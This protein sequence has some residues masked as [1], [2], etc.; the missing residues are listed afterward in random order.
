MFSVIFRALFR[1][2]FWNW[3][4]RKLLWHTLQWI[5]ISVQSSF[6]KKII[7][8]L[9]ITYIGYSCCRCC[10]CS[11]LVTTCW[12]LFFMPKLQLLLTSRSF[13]DF[14]CYRGQKMVDWT[15]GQS[16]PIKNVYLNGLGIRFLE[17]NP[18]K[19]SQ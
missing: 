6:E 17:T 12:I 2:N 1:L 11:M 5:S 19:F 18:V 7:I 3:H 15:A 16:I 14:F 9:D 8:P 13:N 4:K 10:L